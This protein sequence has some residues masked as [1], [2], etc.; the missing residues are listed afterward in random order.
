[1]ADTYI[2]TQK[3]VTRDRQHETITQTT[4]AHLAGDDASGLPEVG[5]TLAV[6]APTAVTDD[7]CQ[8]VDEIEG[9]S[10]GRVFVRATFSALK[11]RT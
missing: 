6:A 7:V 4:G 1:M 2:E 5:K 11:A 3:R 10:K 8:S 9:V